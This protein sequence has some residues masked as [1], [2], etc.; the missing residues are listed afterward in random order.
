MDITEY[1]EKKKPKKKSHKLYALL[2]IIL[3][4]AIL[5]LTVLVLFHTQSVKVSGN[6]YTSDT[7]LVSWVK[8]DKYAVNTLYLLAKFEWGEVALPPYLEKVEAGLQNPWTFS[9]QVTEKKIMGG[10]PRGNDYVY[11]D[12]NGFVV[13]ITPDKREGVPHV[14]GLETGEIKLYQT[15]EVADEK[16]FQNILDVSE[17][18]VQCELTP[19][20]IEC[21]GK[22]I[23]LYF[24]N[25]KVLLGS[26]N[27]KN[28]ILQ[29]PPI[30]EKLEGQMGTLHLEHY[31]D[32]SQSIS[33]RVED[34][35][36][37]PPEEA[38]PEL[39]EGQ[40]MTEG[41]T[42]QSDGYEEDGAY[43]DENY[44]QDTASDRTTE[45]SDNTSGQEYDYNTDGSETYNYDSNGNYVDNNEQIY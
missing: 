26:G 30:L 43:S 42:V 31:S 17:M 33:F 6:E 21:A 14:E 11:F 27:M 32:S 36:A 3:G 39:T 23:N 12:K 2:I 45:A 34:I 1:N 13:M 35:H 7:E 9:L 18:I 19:D 8:K 20:R 5:T 15:I 25:I 10:I 29:I 37:A 24:G 38:D 4:I 22:D 41:D 40:E 44:G 28:K 16:V